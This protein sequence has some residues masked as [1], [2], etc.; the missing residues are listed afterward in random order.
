MC[1]PRHP[2]I[3]E[4]EENCRIHRTSNKCDS[5][6]NPQDRPK[7]FIDRREKRND[8]QDMED[9]IKERED[10]ATDLIHQKEDHQEREE[11]S[12]SRPAWQQKT[13][14]GRRHAITCSGHEERDD[15][16]NELA[17][18]RN[19]TPSP[20]VPNKSNQQNDE[21]NIRNDHNA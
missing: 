11:L 10:K 16:A 2:S 17:E 9:R 15:N 4:V 5:D 21:N 13:D 3:I 18:G 1:Q 12:Q 14:P 7:E 6:R 20:S 8:R 19:R